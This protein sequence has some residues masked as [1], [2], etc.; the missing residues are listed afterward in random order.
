MALVTVTVR[1]RQQGLYNMK[2]YNSETQ[3]INS[4]AVVD[5]I[6]S[7]CKKGRND[8]SD[9]LV[10]SKIRLVGPL[11][12]EDVLWVTETVSAIAALD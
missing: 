7:L 5:F 1:G 10:N 3:G 12:E 11:N 9:G 4:N 8:E 6:P 2:S